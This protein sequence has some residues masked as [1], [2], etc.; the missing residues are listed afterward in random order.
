MKKR[1]QDMLVFRDIVRMQGRIQ[2]SGKMMAAACALLYIVLCCFYIIVS[3]RLAASL[4]VTAEQ[5]ALIEI[6]KGLG[7]VL[8]SG[9]LF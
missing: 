4:A 2:D 9:L 1:S 3:G 8:V 7:F 6:Y 5:L